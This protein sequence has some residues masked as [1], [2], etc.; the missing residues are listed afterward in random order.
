MRPITALLAATFVALPLV[1]QAH[2]E[3]PQAAAAGAVRKEQQAWGIAADRQAVTRTVKIT[4]SDTTRFTADRLTVRQG[5]TIRL[6]PRNAGR[7]MHEFVLGTRQELEVHAALMKRFPTMEHDE[8]YVV[9]VPPGET[10]EIV[11]TFNRAGS[12]ELACLIPGHFDAGMVGQV[13]VTA[14]NPKAPR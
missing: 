7:M 2:A 6:F 3:K 10:G 4:I 13:A 12:F 9:N 14:A 5:E 8:P 11:W 1:A